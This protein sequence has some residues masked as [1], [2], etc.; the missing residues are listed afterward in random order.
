MKVDNKIKEGVVSKWLV[1]SYKTQFD[2]YMEIKKQLVTRGIDVDMEY[3]PSDVE[4]AEWLASKFYNHK[5]MDRYT[6]N[7]LWIYRTRDRRMEQKNTWVLEELWFK[8]GIPIDDIHRICE[9][10]HFKNGE[11]KWPTCN[12]NDEG[13]CNK[14]E[15]PGMVQVGYMTYFQDYEWYDDLVDGKSKKEALKQKAIYE[16]SWGDAT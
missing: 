16:G 13:F 9:P 1:R 8:N 2:E 6:K 12:S 7:A 3:D 10:F 11:A 15:L 4:F 5:T 14:G